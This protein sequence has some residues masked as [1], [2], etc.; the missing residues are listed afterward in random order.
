[1]RA[2]FAWLL[3]GAQA[4][5]ST[6]PGVKWAQNS[7][8]L[9]VRVRGHC[10][11]GT[12]ASL[13]TA[14]EFSFL[15]T[16]S[17][18][19][20]PVELRF[21]LREDV[22]V[23]K[24]GST[25][26]CAE[27]MGAKRH[28]C[29]LTKMS[30]GHYWD[31]LEDGSTLDGAL[32]IEW[33]LWV[34]EPEPEDRGRSDAPDPETWASVYSDADDGDSPTVNDAAPELSDGAIEAILR[35]AGAPLASGAAVV[36][37]V[38][39]PWCTQCAVASRQFIEVAR[40][41]ERARRA[42]GAPRDAP[43]HH[44]HFG[45]IDALKDRAF[46]RDIAPTCVARACDLYIFRARA[47]D[48][49]V[50]QTVRIRVPSSTDELRRTV[51]R[52]AAPLVRPIATAAALREISETTMTALLVRPPGA[53]EGCAS[54]VAAFR[55]AAKVLRNSGRD[56]LAS[57]AFA[58]GAEGVAASVIV[59]A[60][61]AS[62]WARREPTRSGAEVV[63]VEAG[64]CALALLRPTPITLASGSGAAAKSAANEVEPLS[65]CD[66]T[67]SDLQ[68]SAAIERWVSLWSLPLLDDYVYGQ[69]EL[70]SKDH[71]DVAVLSV[72]WD[73]VAAQK[74]AEAAAEGQ[75]APAA[76][77]EERAP[78]KASPAARKAALRTFLPLARELRGRAAVVAH[79]R[80]QYSFQLEDYGL[81]TG[82]EDEH[83][84]ALGLSRDFENDYAPKY[85]YAGNLS[86]LGAAGGEADGKL[87]A[88]VEKV[89]AGGMAP[90]V[91]SLRARA[92]GAAGSVQLLVATQMRDLGGG[93]A[94]AAERAARELLGDAAAPTADLLVMAHKPWGGPTLDAGNALAGAIAN[95][96]ATV[97]G[98]AVATFDTSNN[99][100]APRGER[101]DVVFESRDFK[102]L[103]QWDSVPL[104]FF[105]RHRYRPGLS[106]PKEGKKPRPWSLR[107]K[108]SKAV[109]EKPTMARA[110]KLLKWLRV[111][112]AA[113]RTPD[114]RAS[115]K[116]ALARVIA[117][118]A[119][120]KAAADAAAEAEA[121]AKAESAAPERGAAADIDA[122][123]G[124][125]DAGEEG[126]Q[127]E[128]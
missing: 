110:K 72:W 74:S 104:F 90:S 70:F 78:V 48:G 63:A 108:E 38:G 83:Y 11:A 49:G 82:D 81:G 98:F 9:F 92:A 24:G 8:K 42:H 94:D 106:T 58:L 111:K 76:V 23:P 12:A 100:V 95:V 21:R 16:S 122:A 57:I 35:P 65:W 84:P 26:A 3:V 123:V 109:G 87:T 71:L 34:D 118:E 4:A 19:S 20:L 127:R 53:P 32:K 77:G 46:A 52:F 91:K 73:D 6:L 7:E 37:D 126:V 5:T 43:E 55:A 45:R 115:V 50:A 79:A 88:W 107:Y 112:C 80:S 67:Q 54:E 69:R 124:A 85:G 10:V 120:A 66:A 40:E 75:A 125:Q 102:G 101:R 114:A 14:E 86:A 56:R 68:S 15:C 64:A 105:F 28:T 60:A 44:L 62:S 113:L 51:L 17:V 103:G 18:T 29:T 97:P 116:S 61:A 33:S 30:A 96:T 39:L 22:D 59:D 36:V 99:F 41:V 117:A 128:L 13:V 27:E 31:R 121:A 1:M 119:A 89:L 2:C 93:D 47:G 25:A